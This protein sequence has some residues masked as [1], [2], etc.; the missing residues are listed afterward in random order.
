[1][2]LRSWSW[3][4]P[5]RQ[6][7]WVLLAC[8]AIGAALSIHMGQDAS[9]D[10]RNYHLYNAWAWLNGREKTDVAAAGLQSFFN[11]ILDVPYYFLMAGP[12]EHAPRWLAA[13]QGLWYGLLVFFV[14]RIAMTM[15]R[16]QSRTPGLAD[17]L[18]IAI[19]A[20]GTIVASREI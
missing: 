1:M 4:G 20:T 14:Y 12:L 2:S 5:Q 19:G 3:P 9:W 11:P 16:L 13:T 7:L 17:W 15:A 6:W 8:L 18:A 10:L